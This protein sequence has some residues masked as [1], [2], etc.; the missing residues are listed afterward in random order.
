MG[1]LLEECRHRCATHSEPR[2]HTTRISSLPALS[3]K[4][5]APRWPQDLGRVSAVSLRPKSL[6]CAA[7][8]VTSAPQG[9]LRP[10]RA[11]LSAD[12]LAGGPALGRPGHGC[13]DERL[14]RPGSSLETGSLSRPRLRRV[15]S[16]GRPWELAGGTS[17]SWGAPAARL[18]PSEP[19]TPP[20]GPLTSI[21]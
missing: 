3:A 4:P 13:E 21:Y 1:S 15:G 11:T 18:R 12:A 14:P 6:I 5:R 9:C 20:G 19:A 7:G 2:P 17:P 10:E 8:T 16:P